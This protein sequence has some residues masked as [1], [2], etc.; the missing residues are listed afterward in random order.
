LYVKGSNN[1][2]I[3]NETGSSL[4]IIITPPFWMTW[5]FRSFGV[6]LL[7]SIG[8]LVY[9]RRINNLT[10]EKELQQEIS[11]LIIEKQEEER[12]RIALEMHDSLGQDLLF[13][14]NRL[15][16]TI[17]KPGDIPVILDNLNCIS[18]DISSVLKNVREISHNLRP[19]DL[20][21][22]G[23]TETILS[24]LLTMRKSTSM[25]VTGNVD[26]IDG[27]IPQNLEINLVRIIQEALGNVIRHADASECKVIVIKQNDK[28]LLEINDNGKGFES[29]NVQEGIMS[30]SKGLG[31]TGITERVRIMG[32]KFKIESKT[33]IGTQINI[34]IPVKNE[35]QEK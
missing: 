8:T 23:L 28:I 33:G 34:V 13:I 16:L 15:L 31:L 2:G 29:S 14:K 12:S 5:W 19:P 3:W 21:Q 7:L 24:I 6:I 25:R 17:N 18:E 26:N 22:L 1:D 30:K 32:G 27:F 9:N 4:T 35:I 10:R 20:D 11:R